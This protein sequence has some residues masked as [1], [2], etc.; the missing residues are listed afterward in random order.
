MRT[1]DPH[2]FIHR[3]RASGMTDAVI[4]ERLLL[5]GWTREIIDPIFAAR[6]LPA[7]QEAVAQAVPV[8]ASA[9]HS[10]APHYS[11]IGVAAVA[12]VMA[13]A[14]ALGG[15]SFRTPTVYSISLPGTDASS[16]APAL[17]YG[18]L[19]ALEDSAYYAQVRAKLVGEKASFISANLTAMQLEVYQGGML[20]LTVPILAKGKVGSWW[21]TPVGIYKIETKEKDHYSSFGHVHQPWSMEFQGNFFIHGWPY[22]DDGTPVATS[23][24]GGCIRLS[25]DDA[26]KVF[27]LAS[28]GMPVIVYKA[29]ASGDDFS[30]RLKAPPVSASG[31]LVADIDTGTVLA[32]ESSSQQAPIAS[33]T[34]LVTALVATEYVNLDKQVVVPPEAIVYTTLPRL[35]PGTSVRAYDLLYLLLQESSNEAAETLAAATGRDNFVSAM[36]AK[37]RAIGLT[38]TSFN[39]PSGAKEDLSTPEDLFTLLRYIDANRQFVFK[40]TANTLKDSAYGQPVFGGIQD[41]NFVKGASGTFLGGKVG[42]TNEAGETYA[43]VFAVPIGGHQRQIAVIVLGSRDSSRDVVSLLSFVSR[44]YAAEDSVAVAQ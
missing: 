25:T 3:L 42:Q 27:G 29:P 37:A 8:P 9:P 31:Y 13:V 1:D 14:G 24:S 2:P 39:D 12:V 18:A 35:K 11:V 44:A 21:E 38:H 10:Y 28:K 30:Y 43:G 40:I 23:Y 20:A 16:S 34:K 15:F 41:F 17:A 26:E 4:H 32:S 5:E 7:A 36:N 6:G 19:P 33:I 22:Y